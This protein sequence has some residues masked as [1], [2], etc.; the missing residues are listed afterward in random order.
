MSDDSSASGAAKSP[1]PGLE[2]LG[3]F[4]RAQRKLMELSQR[5]L[6]QLTQLSNPYVSQLERGLHEPSVRVL[7]SLAGALNVRAETLLSYAG[8]LDPEDQPSTVDAILADSRLT[9]DQKTALLSVYRSFID[10]D[11]SQT[12]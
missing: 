10:D 6:A 11:S 5:E 4:I 8:L 7:R 3:D 12:S 2:Q 1:Y 9:E